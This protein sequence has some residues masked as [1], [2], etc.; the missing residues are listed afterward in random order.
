M[1]AN[2][3]KRQAT[4]FTKLKPTRIGIGADSYQVVNI[5]REGIGIQ[6]DEDHSFYLGQRLRA[7]KIKTRSRSRSYDGLITH[8]THQHATVVCGIRFVLNDIEG[9]DHMADYVRERSA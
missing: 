9:Y 6:I 2:S 4:R 8:I 3:E 7:I 5:S 1:I